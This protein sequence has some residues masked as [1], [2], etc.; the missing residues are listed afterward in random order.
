MKQYYLCYPGGK[1]KALTMSYDDGRTEDRRLVEIFNRWGLKG[2]FHLNGGRFPDTGGDKAG[3]DRV[4][5]SEVADLYQGH[6]V[7]CHTLTHPTIERCPLP[8]VAQE[9]LEDRKVLE[10]LT[11]YPVQGL[12]YPNGSFTQEIID[13]LPALGIEYSRVVGSHHHY[14]LPQDWYRWQATCHHNHDLLKHGAEFI[15]LE[16]KQYLYLMYVWGHSFEFSRD[17]NW[18][19]MESF[20]EQVGQREDIWYCTNLEFKRYMDAGRQ[21]IYTVDGSQVL[22][23]SQLPVWIAVDGE[24]I[25]LNSGLNRI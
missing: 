3:A 20:A 9:I 4:P 15:G 23:L 12:S 11:Q 16:K 14:G 7:A 2:T 17:D 1:F 19:L 5:M 8:Q 13:L 10:S 24:I 25:Q 18:A 22:N 6:E 21:L